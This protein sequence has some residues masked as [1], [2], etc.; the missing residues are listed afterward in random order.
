MKS[1]KLLLFTLSVL[2]LGL[3]AGSVSAANNNIVISLSAY[4]NGDASTYYQNISNNKVGTEF[5]NELHE[6][7]EE[8]RQRLIGYDNMPGY[9]VQTDPGSSSGKVTSFY[10]GTSAS[11]SGNMNR[12]HVWPASRTVGG[13]GSDP[14]EDDIHMVRPTLTSENSSRGNKFFTTSDGG[15]W[16]PATFNNPSYRGDSARIIF[17]SVVS[18]TRLSIVDISDD[19]SYN[20]TMGKLSDLLTWNL[21]YSVA[22]RERVRNEAAESLQGNR[23]PFIDHPEY[24]CRI[25]GNTN[26][27]TRSICGMDKVTGV[28]LSSSERKISVGAAIRLQY[29]IEP[30]AL[31]NE[32][33]VSWSTS[34]D[35]VA[36]VSTSGLITGVSVG[37]AVITITVNDY[38]LSDTCTIT[39]VDGSSSG[40][41]NGCGGNI[42]T[43]SMVLSTI[44]L[45]GIG[46]L[47]IRR[48]IYK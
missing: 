30:A 27:T 5:L 26:Q 32:V 45:I 47:L 37:Q 29:T 14:L 10:S 41:N 35:K 23:N 36:S 19:Y 1:T 3:V 22:E 11:Y 7:N 25:W 8:K 33:T 31:S 15:G 42:A 43:T 18:D 34:D 44:S 4:P 20:H 39:V 38:N 13:R 28:T 40:S 21:E 17:Y 2:S 6:L 12:E 48:R 9:F 46:L 16:D 24:A